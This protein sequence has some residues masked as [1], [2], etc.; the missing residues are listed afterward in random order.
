[1][2]D[3]NMAEAILE[4]ARSIDGLTKAVRD[5]GNGDAATSM[6]ANGRTLR[7]EISKT[8]ASE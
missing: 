2:A 4:V 7:L 1:M 6:G 8:S 5:L 3:D